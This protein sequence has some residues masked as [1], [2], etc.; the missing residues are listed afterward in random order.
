MYLS[1]TDN[2]PGNKSSN[3]LEN[4]S[5]AVLFINLELGRKHKED[6]MKV[7]EK[8]RW[9]NLYKIV[10]KIMASLRV[11]MPL[12]GLKKITLGFQRCANLETQ[13]QSTGFV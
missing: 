3:A 5:F 7:G 2:T 12:R 6:Y 10:N 1:Q 8:A 11:V 13:E 9:G 4:D